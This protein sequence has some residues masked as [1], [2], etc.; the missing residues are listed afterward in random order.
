MIRYWRKGNKVK[1]FLDDPTH[2]MLTNSHAERQIRDYVVFHQ[3]YFNLN[4]A[5]GFYNAYWNLG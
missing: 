4:E 2:I 1:K 5:I 3:N